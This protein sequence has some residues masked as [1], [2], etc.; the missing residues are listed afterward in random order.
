[1]DIG[2]PNRAYIRTLKDKLKQI[3]LEDLRELHKLIKGKQDVL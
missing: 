3:N 1:M 2:A